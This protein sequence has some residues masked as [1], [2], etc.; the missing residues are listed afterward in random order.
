MGTLS[1][2]KPREIFDNCKA[3]VLDD[4]E[5]MIERYGMS[6]SEALEYV[7]A[8]EMRRQNYLYRANGDAWDE[9]IADIGDLLKS[10][11]NSL[12]IIADKM[13]ENI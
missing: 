3:T 10:I 2:Q 11:D 12:R 1:D 4:W 7:K 13:N 8:V 9:Q 6:Q 5:K